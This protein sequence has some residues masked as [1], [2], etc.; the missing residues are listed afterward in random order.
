MTSQVVKT[1]KQPTGLYVLFLTEM[2]ERFSYYAMRGILVLYLI[3]VLQFSESHASKLYGLVTSL[4]YL[5]PLLGGYIADKF[6]GQRRA[7]IVGQSYMELRDFNSAAQWY[8]VAEKALPNS[9]LAADAA[10]RRL[11]CAQ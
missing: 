1:D 8:Q 5:S 11:I 3:K 2:W 4:I 7:I 9:A 10:Y 6:W